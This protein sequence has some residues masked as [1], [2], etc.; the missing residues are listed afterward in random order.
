MQPPVQTAPAFPSTQSSA[1][2]IS[3]SGSDSL[4]AT[5]Q[6]Q[7]APQ[8]STRGRKPKVLTAEEK[9]A[10]LQHRKEK[11]KEFAQ[12][13]RNR[14]RK[15]VEEM[16]ATNATLSERV[17]VLEA[18]NASLMARVLALTYGADSVGSLLF[19]PPAPS[20]STSSNEPKGL[21]SKTF[22]NVQKYRSRFS[23][24]FSFASLSPF[25][26]PHYSQH[27]YPLLSFFRRRVFGDAASFTVAQ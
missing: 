25:S 3:P 19:N 10:H 24:S 8:K 2:P 15:H 18:Q 27:L 23:T 7:L 22:E 21:M 1:F 14:K 17:R 9:E 26:K 16:E 4:S 20:L 12:V 6:N 13:S 5:Q 11:N